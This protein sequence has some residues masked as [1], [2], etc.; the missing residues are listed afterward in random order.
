MNERI[1]YEHTYFIYQF[2]IDNMKQY[3]TNLLEN[4]N[5]YI[6]LFEKEKDIDL[7]SYFQNKQRSYFFQVFNL[8]KSK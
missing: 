3:I 7:Y 6:N 5:I 4:K 2:Q 8:K 1:R